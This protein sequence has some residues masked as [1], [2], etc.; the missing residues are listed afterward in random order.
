M[1]LRRP[2]FSIIGLRKAKATAALARRSV[3]L[4]FV[5]WEMAVMPRSARASLWASW[6]LLDLLLLEASGRVGFR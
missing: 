5:Y 1:Q 6:L 4:R 2:T 3:V